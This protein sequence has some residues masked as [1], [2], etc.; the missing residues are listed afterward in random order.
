V[1]LAV[2]LKL[3]LGKVGEAAGEVG[4]LAPFSP[5]VHSLR[6]RFAA[7]KFEASKTRE[8]SLCSRSP[9][10]ISRTNKKQKG[11]R[12]TLENR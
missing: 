11:Q 10:N 6:N 12:R 4:R 2:L 3:E 7:Q 5:M 8:G 1:G 9:Q